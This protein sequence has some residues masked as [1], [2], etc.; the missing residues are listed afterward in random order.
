MLDEN[1]L[2]KLKIREE[3]ILKSIQFWNDR[4]NEK[5]AE[6]EKLMES[7]VGDDIIEKTQNEITL[8]KN[9]IDKEELAAHLFFEGK[10][11]LLFS[12]LLSGINNVKLT[13]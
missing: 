1:T 7:D 8:I 3:T 5:C 11:K 6:W 10:K 13:E 2:E 4:A 12:N 9:R